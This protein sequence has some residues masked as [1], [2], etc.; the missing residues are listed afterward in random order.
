MPPD[1][2]SSAAHGALTYSFG[3]NTIGLIVLSTEL[4]AEPTCICKSLQ[5]SHE[6]FSHIMDNFSIARWRSDLRFRRADDRQDEGQ[7]CANP[8][9]TY[10][11]PG[12]LLM[13]GP[14]SGQQ[15][16]QPG[17][18]WGL[19]SNRKMRIPGG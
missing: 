14:R 8:P 19:H 9:L 16:G 2:N 12:G 13:P 7:H 10:D 15:W 11:Q 3:E 17:L 5:T 1:G 4:T 18:T 6:Q